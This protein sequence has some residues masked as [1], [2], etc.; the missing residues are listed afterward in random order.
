M[1]AVLV[2]RCSDPENVWVADLPDCDGRHFNAI[3]RKSSCGSRLCPADLKL[4]QRRAQRRLVAARDAFWKSHVREVGMCERFVTLTGPTL[5]GVS[6]KDC[7]SIFNRAFELLSDRPFWS[8]RIV[9]GAKHLEFTVNPRGYHA[10]IHLLAYGRYLER[11]LS[12]EDK[13]R[14]WRSTRA[15]KYAHLRLVKDTLPPIGNL[16]DEW[17][18]CLTA[19]VREFGMVIEWSAPENH[20][21][22]YSFVT[23]DGVL[24]ETQPTT[25]P[26]ANV[27]VCL[28]RDKSRP[29]KE[30]IALHSAIKELTKYLTKASSWSKVSDDQLVEIAEVQR[31]P[32]CFEL[33]GEWRRKRSRCADDVSRPVL[34]IRAGETWEEFCQRVQCEHGD[35]SSYVIVWDALNESHCLYAATRGDSASLDTDFV[36]REAS[37]PYESPPTQKLLIRPRSLPL[38]Q[39]GESMEF[40]EWLKLCAIR[41]AKARRSRSRLLGKKF[42][43]VRFYCL[44]G[45]EFGFKDHLSQASSYELARAA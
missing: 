13:T 21:G 10:H 42:P 40:E 5:Q 22:R 9:A 30:E 23:D 19:A 35:P 1:R 25:A 20:G 38:M 7:T 43:N 24:T 3:G 37:E 31:W 8:S 26:K 44:D 33:L 16:Q 11:D 39:L 14:E 2:G 34:H 17:T 32:R 36:F 18:A 6:L 41:L 27:H 15:E 29:G 45:T 28:V 12:E 4:I